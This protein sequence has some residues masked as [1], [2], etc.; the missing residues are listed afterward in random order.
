AAHPG[1]SLLEPRASSDPPRGGVYT[2]TGSRIKKWLLLLFGRV[3]EGESGA[4]FAQLSQTLFAHF[5]E[6]VAPHLA[7]GAQRLDDVV[8][9]GE[10]SKPLVVGGHDV[11]G[12]AR[13]RTATENLLVRFLKGVPFLARLPVADVELPG[14]GR[15]ALA[16]GEPPLLLALA[17]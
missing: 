13:R 7:I 11:P 9:D 2:L 3:S 10:V 4:V 16:V 5:V 6:L 14:L 8:Q 12:G 15:I 1:R 17:D